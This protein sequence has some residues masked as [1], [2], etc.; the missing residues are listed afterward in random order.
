MVQGKEGWDGGGGG[1]ADDIC[2]P[3]GALRAGV[4]KGV[5]G[6]EVPGDEKGLASL[7]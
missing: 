6:V 4:T 7:G 2:E 3:P 5:W 1:T